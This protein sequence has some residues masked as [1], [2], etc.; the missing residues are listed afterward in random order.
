M[1]SILLLCLMIMTVNAYAQL[2][3]MYSQ[4]MTN[5]Y[6]VN[7]AVSGV[8]DHSSFL[9]SY[10]SQWN[11]IEGAP[12]QL[13]ISV[14]S[15]LDKRKPNDAARRPKQGLGAIV[16]FD[17]IGAFRRQHMAVTYAYHLPLRDM[18]WSMGLSAGF[19]RQNLDFSSINFLDNNDPYTAEGRF[20]PDFSFSMMGYS[21][22]FY[23]GKAGSLV[24]HRWVSLGYEQIGRDHSLCGSALWTKYAA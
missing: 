23:V 14:N 16:H 11:G 8:D 17:K 15:H 24:C 5:Q 12:E 18:Y 6:L 20:T 4:Y 19:Q 10:R 1:K 22:P 2:L 7:P 9:M 21:S 3:P 13:Y